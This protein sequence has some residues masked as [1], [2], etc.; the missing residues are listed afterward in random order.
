MKKD[1]IQKTS[2]DSNLNNTKFL[3]EQDNIIVFVVFSKGLGTS[4]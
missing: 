4:V 2:L 1:V 3:H